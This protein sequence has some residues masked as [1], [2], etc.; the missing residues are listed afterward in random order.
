MSAVHLR[1][2]GVNDWLKFHHH[3]II[4]AAVADDVL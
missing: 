4:T 1:N 3:E 2:Q